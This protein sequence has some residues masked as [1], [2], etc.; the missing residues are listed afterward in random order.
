M[1]VNV[2][3]LNKSGAPDLARGFQ[4]SELKDHGIIDLIQFE[5]ALKSQLQA[6]ESQSYYCTQLGKMKG[7]LTVTDHLIL[8]LPDRLPDS[9]DN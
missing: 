3:N 6:L 8:F 5:E 1:E 7:T 2:R 9:D 4:G